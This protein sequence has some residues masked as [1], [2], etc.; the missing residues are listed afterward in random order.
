VL[1]LARTRGDVVLQ[2]RAKNLLERMAVSSP[3]PS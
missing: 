2:G 3:T 1:D